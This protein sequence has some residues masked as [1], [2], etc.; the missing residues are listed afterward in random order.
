MTRPGVDEAGNEVVVHAVLGDPDAGG[1]DETLDPRRT[2]LSELH[3]GTLA[4]WVCVPARNIVAKPAELTFEEAACLPTAW[5][6]AYRM[7]FTKARVRP[8]DR[9][10]VQG[11]G[12]GVAVAATVLASHAGCHVTVTSRSPERLVRAKALGAQEVLAPGTRLA[13]RADVVIE[14]VGEATWRH[15]LTSLRP[16][17]TIVVAGATTGVAPA[18]ELN[19]VFFQQLNVLGSTMGTRAELEALLRFMVASGVRPVIDSTYQLGD[20]RAAFER[21]ASGEQF[22][23]IVV[24]ARS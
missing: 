19:R 10:L 9:V 22:G 16:G 23:K 15:S 3:D 4:E 6:T 12:G 20:A 5:L 7:L 21:L 11:A 13:R 2:L 8:G 17:G 14:T 24:I 1:G 18:A